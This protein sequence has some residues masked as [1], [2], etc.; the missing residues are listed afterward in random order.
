MAPSSSTT[1]ILVWSEPVG[2]EL[3]FKLA[4]SVSP[5]TVT[6]VEANIL[7][8]VIKAVASIFPSTSKAPDGSQVSLF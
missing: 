8:A 3:T 1:T 5:P 7:L 6:F 4:V 2:I